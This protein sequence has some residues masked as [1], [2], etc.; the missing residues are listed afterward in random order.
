MEG[1]PG[2]NKLEHQIQPELDFARSVVSRA[3]RRTYCSR[4]R[5]AAV[6][7]VHV[8]TWR[9]TKVRMVVHI[10]QLTL[11]THVEALGDGYLLADRDV[12]VEI[13]GPVQPRIQCK[14]PRI[15][16]RCDERRVRAR[17]AQVLRIDQVHSR[18]SWDVI[19]AH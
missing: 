10:Q 15:C 18:L 5:K 2:R 8:P 16:I 14:R 11:E 6:V 7:D 4:L 1:G 3:V 17:A 12:L 13:A 9:W 19:D